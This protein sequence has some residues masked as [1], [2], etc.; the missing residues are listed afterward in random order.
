MSDYY[1][2]VRQK[3]KTK[4][5]MS[6]AQDSSAD[7]QEQIDRLKEAKRIIKPEK[8]EFSSVKRNIYN[9]AYGYYQWRG[10]TFDSFS[11]DVRELNSQCTD[12]YQKIDDVIDSINSKITEIKNRMEENN[13]I[14][15]WCRSRLRD[16]GT[17]IENCLN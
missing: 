1:S 5:R 6:A 13:D 16:L 11:E 17:L 2:L 15:G 9:I 10:D 14:I 12:Y 4:S 7:L 3:E 8:T